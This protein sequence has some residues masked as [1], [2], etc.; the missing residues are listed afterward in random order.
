MKIPLTSEK[1]VWKEL[2]LVFG[3]NIILSS[4]SFVFFY[5]TACSIYGFKSC[6]GTPCTAVTSTLADAITS[7]LIT[8]QGKARLFTLKW[9]M[10]VYYVWLLW[11]DFP[12]LVEIVNYLSMKFVTALTCKFNIDGLPV[13]SDAIIKSEALM[14]LTGLDFSALKHFQGTIIKEWTNRITQSSKN[15]QSIFVNIFPICRLFH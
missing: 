14:Y 1:R 12:I 7:T 15:V 3:H 13:R 6:S 2:L 5:F 11:R 9:A 10:T 8:V 4:V